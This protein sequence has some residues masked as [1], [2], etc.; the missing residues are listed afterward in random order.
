MQSQI[1]QNVRENYS[2]IDQTIQNVFSPCDHAS[3]NISNSQ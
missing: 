3:S 1:Y 2:S